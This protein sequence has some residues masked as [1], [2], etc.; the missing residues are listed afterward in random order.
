[1]SVR[2]EETRWFVQGNELQASFIDYCVKIEQRFVAEKLKLVWVVTFFK[3][4]GSDI[5]KFEIECDS[6]E[7]TFATINEYSKQKKF[8]DLI[9]VHFSDAT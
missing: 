5:N 9:T 3:E 4:V 6:L 7:T 8:E 1:M 2:I